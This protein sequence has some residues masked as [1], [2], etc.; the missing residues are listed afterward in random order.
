MKKKTVLNL[1]L[2]IFTCSLLVGCNGK[3]VDGTNENAGKDIKIIATLFPQYD[4]AREIAGDKAD[5]T[6]LM[7]PGVESHS[8]EPSPSDIIDI[9]SSD[10]FIYTGEYME[11][12]AQSIIEGMDNKNVK[13]L[14]V[15]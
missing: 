4:F 1:F 11:P 2:I 14:D 3:N 9:N 6:L 12:W 13:I 7:S 10:L 5:I 8:Y 15:S